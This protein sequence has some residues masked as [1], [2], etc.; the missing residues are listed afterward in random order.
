MAISKLSKTVLILL[1]IFFISA[2]IIIFVIYNINNPYI[3]KF[4]INNCE[5][6][7]FVANGRRIYIQFPNPSNAFSLESLQ[8][9]CISKNK[10]IK[11]INIYKNKPYNLFYFDDNIFKSDTLLINLKG[12]LIKIYD[13]RNKGGRINGGENRGE[14][15]CELDMK[16]NSITS[17]IESDTIYI[18]K[19]YYN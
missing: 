1:S 5:K 17:Y 15:Y 14:Y 9:L 19:S 16:I 10:E 12:K 8:V 13:F 6:S 4:P 11:K 7:I 18:I 2:I 3:N